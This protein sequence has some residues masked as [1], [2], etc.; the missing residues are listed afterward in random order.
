MVLSQNLGTG[1]AFD[2]FDRFVETLSGKDTLH[3][4]V[5][6]AYQI[7]SEE[8]TVEES[9]EPEYVRVAAS[10]K[11]RRR[12]FQEAGLDIEPYRKK[13]RMLTVPVLPLDDPRRTFEPE[14][15]LNARV[16]G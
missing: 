16:Y 7:V 2:N 1:G 11:K 13:P 3:D 4:T 14:S 12:A 5:G 9:G 8:P 15:Y 10:R 6:I